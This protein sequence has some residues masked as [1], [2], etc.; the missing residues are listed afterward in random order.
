M[1]GERTAV[2]PRPFVEVVRM[3][4]VEVALLRLTKDQ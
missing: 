3:R 4:N 1:P 2:L